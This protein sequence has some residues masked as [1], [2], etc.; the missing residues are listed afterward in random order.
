LRFYF[1][2]IVG[3]LFTTNFAW[4]I[5]IREMSSGLPL[6]DNSRIAG[7]T[8]GDLVVYDDRVLKFYDR[9]IR[10]RKT[11]TLNPDQRPVVAPDG[12]HYALVTPSVNDEIT[13][14]ARLVEV[15][16]KKGIL[17]WHLSGVPDGEM[18]LAPGGGYLVVMTGTP[19]HWDWEM[20]ICHG[21]SL[22]SLVSLEA[23]KGIAFANDARRFMVDC[24]PK[25]LRLF[26]STGEQIADY[27]LQHNF[28]FSD[29]SDRA[30][31]CYKGILKIYQDS[32][33][34]SQTKLRETSINALIASDTA[35]R[36]VVTSATNLE[37]I[38][39]ADGRQLWDYRLPTA[40]LNFVSLDISADGDFIAC[41]VSHNRGPSYEKS[42]RYK[43]DYLYLFD[44]DRNIM[45]KK[46]F[47]FDRWRSGFPVVAF[48]ID[49]RSI[50]IQNLEK[51]HVVEMQ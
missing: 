35:D 13:P 50:L 20:L 46:K 47:T 41:G 42:E 33:L 31:V 8:S 25:G 51:L 22:A 44:I 39:L 14:G 36:I 23:F 15:Y 32:M 1:A 29:R 2:L 5:N 18:Y 27:G 26:A 19:G 37:V 38:D 11:L 6:S 21:D 17:Q 24:N 43:E 10:E 49:R 16:D 34:Q 3:I 4:A 40:Q 45:R 28:C 30:V 7:M 48:W 12:R 9:R